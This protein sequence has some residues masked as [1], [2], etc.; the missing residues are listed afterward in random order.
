[1]L[2]KT[3]LEYSFK[4]TSQAVTLSSKSKVKVNGETVHIDPQLLFQRLTAAADRLYDSQEEIFKYELCSFPS[5][6]FESSGL[7]KQADKP[8]L[9]NAILALGDCLFSKS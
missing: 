4:R 3:V 6:L 9:A 2:H 7:L 8:S 5:S 1:M